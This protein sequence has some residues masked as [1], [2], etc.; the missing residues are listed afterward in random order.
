M[1]GPVETA[2]I[3]TREGDYTASVAGDAGAPLVLLL[4]GFPH[5]RHTWRDVLPALAIAGFRAVAPDQ[6]GYSP[7]VR[8]LDVA[9]YTTARLCQDVIDIAEVSG[10]DT[11]HVVGHDWGGQVAWLT[12]AHHPERVRSVTSLSRP[13]PAAFARALAIDPEQRTRSRHHQRFL[14][15]D[16]VAEL[17]ADGFSG[18]RAG[19]TLNGVSETDADVYLTVL[20]DRAALDAALNWYRAAAT[21]TLGDTGCPDVTAPSLYLWG[22][23]DISVGRTAAQLTGDHVKGNYRFVEIPRHGHFLMDDGAGP[24]VTEA[25]LDH[26]RFA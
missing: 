10:Y 23:S 13:H 20:G 12:A 7:G 26:L 22:E 18:L 1:A 16:A 5:T 2:T 24:A 4:H 3:A 6:R 9:A 8:P 25:L 14:A 19:L 21:E 15:P 11:F 17:A